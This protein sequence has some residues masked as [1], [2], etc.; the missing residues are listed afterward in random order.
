MRISTLFGSSYASLMRQKRRS[1]ITMIS[2]AWAVVCFLLLMSS[3]QG[4]DAALRDAFHAVGQDLILMYGGQ[5]SEQE[6]EIGHR[7]GRLDAD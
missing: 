2:L 3:G 6:G 5:T 7:L 4:F 1:F